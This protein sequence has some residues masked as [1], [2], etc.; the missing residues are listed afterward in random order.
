MATSTLKLTTTQKLILDHSGSLPLDHSGSGH[1]LDP[2]PLQKV[3]PITGPSVVVP[4]GPPVIGVPHHSLPLSLQRGQKNSP[5]PVPQTP[6]RSPQGGTPSGRQVRQEPPGIRPE[7]GTL[8]TGSGLA[9]G[10]QNAT[11]SNDSV[12]SSVTFLEQV[13]RGRLPCSPS[14]LPSFAPGR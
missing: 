8:A 4:G 3:R 12:P 10:S 6:T 9:T 11:V 13:P 2:S 1:L 5:H 14:F 7:P